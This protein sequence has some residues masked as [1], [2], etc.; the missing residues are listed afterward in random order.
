MRKI[1]PF[2]R[3]ADQVFSQA[4]VIKHL[5]EKEQSWQRVSDALDGARDLCGPDPLEGDI[6]RVLADSLAATD[7]CPKLLRR[8]IGRRRD[9]PDVWYDYLAGYA[10]K[11]QNEEE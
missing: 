11:R 6:L 4:G 5:E 2:D 3:K 7:W 10:L 9:V 1:A 8:F